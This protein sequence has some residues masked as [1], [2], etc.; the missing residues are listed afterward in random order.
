MTTPSN[1]QRPLVERAGWAV[2]WNVAFFPL[3]L[4]IPLLAT[5]VIVRQ[6]RADGFAVYALALALLDSLGLWS[7]FGIE[8]TLPRFLPE[9]ELRHGRRGILRFL[10]AI[11]LIK[12][13][14]LLVLVGALAVAPQYWIDQF[15]LG[16]DGGWILLIICALLFL[17]AISDISI[18]LLYTHFR[19][20]A[21]NS[22]DVMVAIVRPT[23]MAGFVLLGWGALGA[24]LAL[25]ITTVLAVAISVWLAV[26]MVMRLSDEPH[27]NPDVVKTPS[28]KPLKERVTRFAG[29]NYLIN[30]S[31]YLYDLDFVVLLMPIL[32][33]DDAEAKVQTA[34]IAL[35]YKFT[36]E[37]LRALVVPLTGIQIP[38]FS[39][40]YAENRIDGLR[41]AYA[42]ITKVLILLLLPSAVGLM[43]T[44]RNLLQIM[45][46]QVGGDAVFNPD[47]AAMIVTSTV[48]LAFGLF[49][50]AMISVALN[51]LMVYEDYRAVISARL[52]SLISIPLLIVLIPLY[53]AVGGAIAISVAALGSRLAALGISLRKAGLTFPTQFFMRVGVA[54]AVMGIALAPFLIYLPPN[55]PVTLIMVLLGVAVFYVVFKLV[56][57]MDQS[58]KD[59]F[60]SL[61]L[62][63][64]KQ[65]LRFL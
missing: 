40:L 28:K 58:D 21:T 42:T 22:L 37:F 23:L 27:P 57:G 17:G 61:R 11:G 24:L 4:L 3:K 34:A 25:L 53:G 13:G 31:V 38:L 10:S 36:K 33:I 63:F 41:T 12:G 20:R 45:V 9:I 1:P 6:L 15:A 65:V 43:L 19:Q 29:L 2:F 51:V 48:I 62:P 56:G 26:R 7:D 64:V 18:Q 60:L 5:I 49:G 47:S 59:R 35:A 50:E 52:V 44:G 14:I 30:W 39:R 46:G 32:I 55:I 54:S 8:R 16:P